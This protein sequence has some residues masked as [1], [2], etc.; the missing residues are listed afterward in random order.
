MIP[1]QNRED[2]SFE[3]KET[4]AK[5]VKR[6]AHEISYKMAGGGGDQ[7]RTLQNFI[8][9]GSKTSLQTLSSLM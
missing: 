4:K 5:E 9:L 3:E 1:V 6:K 2:F 7:R 8:T